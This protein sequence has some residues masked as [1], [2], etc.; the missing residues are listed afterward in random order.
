MRTRLHRGGRADLVGSVV[1][2]LGGAAVPFVTSRRADFQ[3][4]VSRAQKVQSKMEN[5][6][7]WLSNHVLLQN[8]G[9]VNYGDTGSLRKK[10]KKKGHSE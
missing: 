1:S 3:Q 9:E 6:H 8:T 2:I 10:E 7:F 5:S 4:L